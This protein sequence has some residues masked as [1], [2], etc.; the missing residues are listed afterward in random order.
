MVKNPGLEPNSTGEDDTSVGAFL[1]VHVPFCE[2]LL[3]GEKNSGVRTNI[4]LLH[5][6]PVDRLS[7]ACAGVL[8]AC[9]I[10]LAAPPS[11]GLT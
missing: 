7:R 8:L 10:F 5:V 1:F 3:S 11:A 9:T 2:V 6:A 4:E